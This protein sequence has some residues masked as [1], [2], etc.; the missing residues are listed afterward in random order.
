MKSK[1]SA[2]KHQSRED[3]CKLD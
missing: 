3:K 2:K 1:K